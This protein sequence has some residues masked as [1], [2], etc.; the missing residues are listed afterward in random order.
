MSP[1]LAY[2]MAQVEFDLGNKEIAKQLVDSLLKNKDRHF[3]MKKEAQAL[4]A[5]MPAKEAKET[6]DA[7]PKDPA[8]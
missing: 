3:S 2:Y 7:P 6:K 8:K 4:Q 1:D 5:K